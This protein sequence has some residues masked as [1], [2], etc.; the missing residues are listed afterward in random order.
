MTVDVAFV[1]AG[2]VSGRYFD[3]L[4]E[5][6]DAQ[7]VA[8]C[9]VDEEQARAA[10][11]PRNAAVYTDYEDLFREEDFDALYLVT[12]P[13]VRQ[14]PAMMAIER[15]I[16]TFIEK[17]AA[18]H[19]EDARPIAEAIEDAGLVSS[20]GYANRYTEIIDEVTDILDGRSLGYLDG[21]S[22]TGLPG[23]EWGWRRE[24]SGGYPIHMS[25]HV[26]DLVR[27][28]AGDVESVVGFGDHRLEDQVDYE[29]VG[30]TTHRHENGVVS[31]VSHVVDT[32]VGRG[33]RLFAEDVALDLSINANS[34][35]GTVHSEDV[36]IEGQ[37]YRHSFSRLTREFIDAVER[38]DPDAMRT[39]YPDAVETLA[40]TWAANEVFQSGGPVTPDGA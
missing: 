26:Y 34:V 37:G 31:H 14:G 35:T 36:T 8:V 27:Y 12:P 17:P 15:G 3:N 5:I 7:I 22:W 23:S 2:K 33:L 4:D 9:D 6:D 24:T 20:S 30:S 21:Y 32:S 1:G 28:V 29:D 13:F 25:T 19:L 10:A 38:E 39:S 18:V 40:L 16:H 11:E